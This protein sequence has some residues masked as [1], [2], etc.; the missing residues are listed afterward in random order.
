MNNDGKLSGSGNFARF[1]KSRYFGVTTLIVLAILCWGIFKILSPQNFGTSKLMSDYLQTSIQYAV[2]GCGFYFIVVMGLFDFSIGANIV[3]SSMVGVLLSRQFGYFG[4]IGGTLVTGALIGA[5]NG[6]FYSKLKIPS[7]IVTVGLMLI[8]E[9]VANYV[10]RLDTSGFPGKLTNASI[11]AFNHA[12]WNYIVAFI[13]FALMVFILRFTRIGTYCNAIGSNELVAKNMGISVEKYKFIGF[14]LLHFFVGI[15]ALLTVSYGKG[16]LAV[17]GM[18]SMD[19][20]FKPLMGTFFGIAFKKYGCPV[21]AIVIGEFIIT[22][23][24]NGLVALNV[25]TTINDFVTGAVLLAIVTL[26]NRGKL[27]S[28]VK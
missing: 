21:T 11:L 26:T 25:P 20:N 22:M 13:A 24:F 12:P 1:K 8:L 7:M 17:T 15:M 19:R 16:I 2:G 5:F 4:L 18:T 28:V 10:V 27:G 3:L 9:S 14:V 6:V 23:I